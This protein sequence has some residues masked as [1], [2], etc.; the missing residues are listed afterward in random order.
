MVDNFITLNNASKCKHIYCSST[1]DNWQQKNMNI[2]SVIFVTL[3]G[4]M[5]HF[6]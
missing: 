3:E 2:K 5:I 1:Q 6:Y 4:G